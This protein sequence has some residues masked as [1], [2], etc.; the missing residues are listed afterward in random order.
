ML[1]GG[2]RSG[3]LASVATA[4]LVLSRTPLSFMLPQTM[5]WS[6]RL[7]ISSPSTTTTFRS[8]FVLLKHSGLCLHAHV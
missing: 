6:R 1:S 5:L 2:P 3:Q 8:S 7:L 4:T